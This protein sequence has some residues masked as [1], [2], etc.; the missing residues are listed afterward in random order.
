MLQRPTLYKMVGNILDR[1]LAKH[2]VMPCRSTKLAHPLTP[3]LP[4]EPASSDSKGMPA[5]THP[6]D[7]LQLYK[8]EIRSCQVQGA[9]EQAACTHPSDV[10][11]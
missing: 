2:I 11:A 8:G 1:Q 4:P 9:P 5:K 6:A 10:H 7:T 3:W